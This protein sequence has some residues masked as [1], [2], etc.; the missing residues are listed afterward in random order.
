MGISQLYDLLDRFHVPIKITEKQLGEFQI[1]GLD[2]SVI[3]HRALK[4]MESI[5][6][7]SDIDG[8]STAHIKNILDL[9]IKFYSNRCYTIPVFDGKPPQIKEDEIK[10]RNE[11]RE[12][13][14]NKLNVINDLMNDLSNFIDTDNDLMD[15]FNN[16]KNALEKQALKVNEN[17]MKP[18]KE[19]LECLG[20]PYS[21]S[22]EEADIT[23]YHLNQAGVCKVIYSVDA[24]MLI[25]GTKYLLKPNTVKSTTSKSTKKEWILYKLDDILSKLKITH[26][27]LIII[28]ISLGCDYVHKLKGVGIETIIKLIDSKKVSLLK[29]K[30][31]KSQLEIYER[32]INPPKY[33]IK[34]TQ[35]K[36]SKEFDELREFLNGKGFTT[37]EKYIDKLKTMEFDYSKLSFQ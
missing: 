19:L 1:A 29:D 35:K 37:T 3:V 34:I 7:L 4:G 21:Q 24:D 17:L 22:E 23:L 28:S 10:K 33:G 18:I 11:V 15:I 30:F 36:I 26:E 2:M 20:V 5:K 25:Y 31:T 12:E 13:A 9:I 14:E 8:N 27:E 6:S 16:D 32:F